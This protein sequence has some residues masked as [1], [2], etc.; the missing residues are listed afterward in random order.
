MVRPIQNTQAYGWNKRDFTNLSH[1]FTQRRVIHFVN[2][3][4]KVLDCIQGS[5]KDDTSIS[6]KFLF[7]SSYELRT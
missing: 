4:M 1:K 6:A 7:L 2:E 5:D 3:Q